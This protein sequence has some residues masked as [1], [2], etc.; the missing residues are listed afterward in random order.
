MTIFI[1]HV[2]KKS[3]DKN[4]EIEVRNNRYYWPIVAF[5]ALGMSILPFDEVFPAHRYLNLAAGSTVVVVYLSLTLWIRAVHLRVLTK[6]VKSMDENV[7]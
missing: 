2:R 3:A 5:L 6:Y 1:I 7:Q 4:I